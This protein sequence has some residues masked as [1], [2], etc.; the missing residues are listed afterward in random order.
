MYYEIHLY[1]LDVT[2]RTKYSIPIFLLSDQKLM[3]TKSN[4]ISHYITRGLNKDGSLI[5]E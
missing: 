4:T 5:P 2:F 1:Y 3:T